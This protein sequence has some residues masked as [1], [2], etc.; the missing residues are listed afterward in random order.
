MQGFASSKPEYVDEAVKEFAG[1]S[2]AEAREAGI[3][4]GEILN[5]FWEQTKLQ[6][7]FKGVT[8]FGDGLSNEEVTE[9]YAK[10]EAEAQ[11]A[12]KRLQV[13]KSTETEQEK[14]DLRLEV[15]R[16]E[17]DGTPTQ[18]AIRR[19]L[20]E[21]G[22]E[23]RSETQAVK[24]PIAQFADMAYSDLSPDGP[25][26]SY[27][28]KAVLAKFTHGSMKLKGAGHDIARS[29]QLAAGDAAIPRGT[30]GAGNTAG[31]GGSPTWS[32]RDLSRIVEG[33][34]GEQYVPL[35]SL[36]GM[37]PW[38]YEMYKY[39][40]ENGTVNDPAAGP[41]E[42]YPT[43]AGIVGTELQYEETEKSVTVRDFLVFT[44]ITEHMLKYD[45]A[46][47]NRV[48]RRQVR[49]VLRRIDSQ[50][51]NGDGTETNTAAGRIQGLLEGAGNTNQK[52]AGAVPRG[53]YEY[54]V[55]Y[56]VR[57][58][59]DLLKNAA[60]VPSFCVMNV[61]DWAK[62]ITARTNFG[63]LLNEA[64]R[65]IGG[66]TLVP[67]DLI[68]EK[69]VLVGDGSECTGLFGPDLEMDMT[70]NARNNDF[71]KAIVTI[72]TTAYFNQAIFR[73]GAF[74]TVKVFEPSV[75]GTQ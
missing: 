65:S 35:M 68:A 36:I 26:G 56:I 31:G 15:F 75:L 51:L 6:P 50:I 71:E 61:D 54:G 45:Q 21:M 38:G 40:E 14:N 8:V 74:H 24:S 72:R 3:K 7:D 52:A 33:I 62:H 53:T 48:E 9:R 57:T 13:I 4:A 20:K 49:D 28:S 18:E 32:P 10:V 47:V 23:A 41:L 59:G 19:T 39:L 29:F 37:L 30:V 66:M 70:K 1:K 55:D 73:P 5:T 67:T 42:G 12:H 63:M 11:G 58:R 2:E 64:E 22:V 69:T 60:A 34:R 16:S 27:D 44:R 43:R 46:F 25:Q 17:R